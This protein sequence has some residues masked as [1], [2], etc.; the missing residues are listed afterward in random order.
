[1]FTTCPAPE[2]YRSQRLKVLL[3]RAK[4]FFASFG[5]PVLVP[6]SIQDLKHQNDHSN[7]RRLQQCNQST[8]DTR[9]NALG[10]GPTA[11]ENPNWHFNPACTKR[12]AFC[13]LHCEHMNIMTS[14][15]TMVWNQGNSLCKI[16]LGSKL[17]RR[18]ICR[19]PAE[20]LS[21]PG[22]ALLVPGL[23]GQCQAV[24]GSPSPTSAWRTHHP[25]SQLPHFEEQSLW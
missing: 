20:L 14:I 9:G 19:P 1:M 13:K 5:V 24:L 15:R 6:G 8:R 23:P 4:Q 22:P 25:T 7:E 18:T 21:W 2:D 11:P 17:E 10:W 12:H 16:N 3:V